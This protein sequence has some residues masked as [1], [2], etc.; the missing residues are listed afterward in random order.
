MSEKKRR[1]FGAIPALKRQTKAQRLSAIEQ[2]IGEVLSSR[3]K[4]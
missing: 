4:K 2:N 1:A 3:G